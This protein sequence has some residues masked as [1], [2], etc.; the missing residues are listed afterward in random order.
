MA[1]IKPVSTTL[2]I[3]FL[4]RFAL[5][6]LNKN[7]HSTTVEKK[8]K[9]VRLGRYSRLSHKTNQFFESLTDQRATELVK[10]SDIHHK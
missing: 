4:R 1:A 6:A 3:I 9:V 7:T 10:I 8:K 2:R 5:V